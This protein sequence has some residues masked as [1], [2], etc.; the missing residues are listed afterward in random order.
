MGLRALTVAKIASG[1]QA[2]PDNELVG[3]E[4]RTEL[5]V[6]LADA[7]EENPEYFGADGRPGN[8]I[9]EQKAISSFKMPP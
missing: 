5:L 9:G 1:M 8:M 3:L 2:D 6:K 4:G 7:L